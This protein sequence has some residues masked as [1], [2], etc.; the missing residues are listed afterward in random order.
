MSQNQ[1]QFCLSTLIYCRKMKQH[2]CLFFS[3]CSAS[4]RT[5][6]LLK[7]KQLASASAGNRPEAVINPCMDSTSCHI[8]YEEFDGQQ[9]EHRPRTLPCGHT[10][11]SG[12]LGA[13]LC[14]QC[15]A[16]NRAAENPNQLCVVASRKASANASGCPQLCHL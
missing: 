15:E 1:V 12:C 10:L 13:S 9:S 6:R 4:P 8:C 3:E 14:N 7:P 16:I 5:P 11:C 2:L